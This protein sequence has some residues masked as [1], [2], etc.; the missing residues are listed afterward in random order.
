MTPTGIETIDEA[1]YEL[2]DAYDWGDFVKVQFL[3]DILLDIRSLVESSQTH[4]E[5]LYED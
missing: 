1:L 2:T 3:V 4:Q 5:A